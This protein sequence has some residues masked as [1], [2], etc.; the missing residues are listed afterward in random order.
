[1]TGADVS[2]VQVPD[3]AVREVAWAN[4]DAASLREAQRAE[5]TE[6]YGSTDI[7]PGPAPTASDI[8]VFF[9]AYSPDGT[10]VGCGGLR[11]LSPTEAEVKRM[12]V[13]PSQRGTGVATALLTAFEDF[14]RARGY[15]RIV[16][17]TGSLQPDAISFYEREGFTSIP[18][19]GYY[20]GNEDSRCYE[21]PLF[22]S[23]PAAEVS[24]E[25]C[26]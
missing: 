12:F 21:K 1:M 16:L 26:Q 18:N 10:A 22:A 9:V 3:I 17:E 7:E 19:F 13:V 11:Q 23:D 6:R 25:S 14:G 20:A 15:D 24:C 2:R 8:T 5:I 4:E